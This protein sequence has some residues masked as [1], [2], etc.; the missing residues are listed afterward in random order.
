L[1][2]VHGDLNSVDASQLRISLFARVLESKLP[3]GAQHPTW[4]LSLFERRWDGS[5]WSWHDLRKQVSGMPIAVLRRQYPD[6]AEQRL[7]PDLFAAGV[8]GKFWQRRWDRSDW[9][10]EDT[11]RPV[12]SALPD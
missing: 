3:A 7:R 9:I 8:D 6:V 11:G 2:L 4:N 5:S 10:W 12:A 1:A